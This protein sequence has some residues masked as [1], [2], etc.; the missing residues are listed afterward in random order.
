MKDILETLKN[1]DLTEYAP[2]PFWSW[3]N[4]LEKDKLLAQIRDM[5]H[6][7]PTELIAYG[8]LPLMI[9]ENCVIKR[10]TGDCSCGGSTAVIDKT[11]RS[12]PLM[13]ESGHRNTL[14]NAEKLYLADKLGDLKGLGIRWLR[15]CFTTE[16]A[17]ECEEAAAAYMGRGG[18]TPDR[19]TRGLYYRG[20]E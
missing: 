3:N 5:S 17:R 11:G 20:V 4:R 13:A 9:T 1:S 10:R 12:F 18:R 2:I 16:N 15:L 14:Y 6:S 19:M 7:M 8:R